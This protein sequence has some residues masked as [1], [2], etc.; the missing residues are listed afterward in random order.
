MTQSVLLNSPLYCY[1]LQVAQ[2]LSKGV[3]CVKG[4]PFSSGFLGAGGFVSTGLVSSGTIISGTS[5]AEIVNYTITNL[6]QTIPYQYS[7]K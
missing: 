7:N 5:L 3:T 4:V 1:T 2:T 6:V